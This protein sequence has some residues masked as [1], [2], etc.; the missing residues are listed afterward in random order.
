MMQKKNQSIHPWVNGFCEYFPDDWDH[1]KQLPLVV[2]FHGIGETYPKCSLDGYAN[3]GLPR[4]IKDREERGIE[5]MPKECVVF[6]PQLN[7]DWAGGG[8]IG[9]IIEWAYNNYNSDRDRI[10]ITG[11]SMGG[12]EILDWGEQGRVS[13]VTAMLPICAASWFNTGWAQ[14]Y[15][16][17]NMPILMTH[18]TADTTVGIDS[19]RSWKDGLNALGIKPETILK[20]IDGGG[21]NVWDETYSNIDIWDWLFA[22]DKSIVNVIFSIILNGKTYNINSNNTWTDATI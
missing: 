12:G 14:K 15:V 16:D 1:I 19:S 4:Y 2:F 7:Q 21:H 13:D 20:E 9:S 10:Y 11:I 8:T 3:V 22:Q 18:G 17:A 6:M 5:G